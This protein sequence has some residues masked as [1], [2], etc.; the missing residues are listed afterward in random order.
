MGNDRSTQS[1]LDS[2]QC[3]AE[4]WRL[5]WV[6]WRTPTEYMGIILAAISLIHKFFFAPGDCNFSLQAATARTK[7]I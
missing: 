1:E 5:P 6:D 3:R 2:N 7:K 4:P